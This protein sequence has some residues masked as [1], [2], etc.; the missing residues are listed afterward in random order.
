MNIVTFEEVFKER[1]FRIPDYQRGYSWSKK[2]LEELWSDL[3]NTHHSRNAFH[4]AG[5]LTFTDFTKLDNDSIRKE[6]IAV[7]EGKLFINSSYYKG[8]NI[9]DGQQR[10]TTLLILL[11]EF[12]NALEEVE[13][14]K[15]LVDLYFKKEEGGINKYVFG[16]H[17]DVPSHNYLIREIFNEPD[18]EE[19]QTE[20]LYT[21]NLSY[22]KSFFDERVSSLSQLE[23]KQWIDKITKSLLFSVLNLNESK[24]RSLDVSMVFET[25]NFRGKQLSSLERLKNRVLYIVSKQL[26]GSAA[27]ERSRKKVNQA[28][29]EVYKWLGRN[30]SQAMDDDA[31]LKAFW[32]LYFSRADMVSVDFKS[33][34]KHLFTVDF[35]LDPTSESTN[36]AEYKEL[37]AWLECMKKAVVLWYFI[38]NPYAIDEDND[39]KFCSTITIQKSLQRL[40]NFPKGYGK[41]MLNLVLAILMRDLPLKEDDTLSDTTKIKQLKEI[42]YLLFAIERHNIMCFLLQGNNSNLNLEDT[43]RDVN[44]Y[45]SRG[46]A[47]NNDYLINVLLE[48]RVNHFRWKEVIRHIHKGN[49]FKSWAGLEYLLKNIE[50]EKGGMVGSGEPKVY[51]IY[52]EEDDYEMRSMYKDINTMQ[53]VNRDR[54]SYSIGNMFL[55]YNRYDA[56]SFEGIQQKIK[57]AIKHNYRLTN[58]ELGLL[59]Y[60]QW[61]KESIESRGR[62]LFSEFIEK[63]DLPFIQDTEMRKLLLDEI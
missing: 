3:Y 40:N 9:V 34:Q 14:K 6:G 61:T 26:T 47:H 18:Y 38:N 24:E 30:P 13:Y 1:I 56:N 52:P 39:F 55:A 25:L 44:Y 49:R 59:D 57:N 10:L 5:I 20:T 50:D 51:L 11:S 28:W 7:R 58:L 27:V 48:T 31:F 29:L 43:F 21:H 16:Y 45:Y 2:E 33:Y 62:L 36:Y 63:W 42:E 37:L 22:A 35:Y 53:K 46:R 41:Y 60:Q 4:F 8:C 15:H 12:V 19:E 32:L 17:I 23:I 54:Y